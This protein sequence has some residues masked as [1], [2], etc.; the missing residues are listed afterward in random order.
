MA[1]FEYKSDYHLPIANDVAVNAE[2][3]DPAHVSTKT[4]QLN[5]KLIEILEAG[6]RWYEACSFARIHAMSECPWLS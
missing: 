3:F 6:P 5:E 2:K 1:T 4:A